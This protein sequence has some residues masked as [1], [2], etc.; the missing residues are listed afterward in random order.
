MAVTPDRPR[1][2]A[3]AAPAH[4]GV[5]R[6]TVRLPGDAS[7][8]PRQRGTVPSQRPTGAPLAV[9]AVVTTTWAALLAAVPVAAVVALAQLVDAPTVSLTG[10]V[11]Y[12]LAGWLLA[13]G[14]P[15]R[16][17]LG[18]VGLAPLAVTA[19]AA[20]RVARAG[21]HT[22]RAI[23]ARRSGSPRLAGYAAAAVAAVYGLLGAGAAAACRSADLEVSTLRAGLT[24]GF[25]GFVAAG[26]GALRASGAIDRAAARMP[27]VLRD[28][29][30]AGALAGVLLLAAGG[31]LAGVATAVNGKGA[32]ETLASY[33][34]GVAGQA[35]L[36]LVCLAYAPNVA[37]WA[38][39]YLIGPGFAVGVD[40]TVR[41]SDV[42]VG[43][44][45]A[46]P[47]F[48]GLPGSAVGGPWMML[49]GA[50]LAA[51]M[52]AGWVLVRRRLHERPRPHR[53]PPATWS[54]LLG[55]AA[56][57]GPVA[58]LALGAAAYA[59]AGPLGAGRLSVVGPFGWQVALVAA[60]VVALGA[61]LGAASSRAAT[62]RA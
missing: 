26:A 29:V 41:T 55:S 11:R 6:G 51:G 15:L 25:F 50:P 18:P 39:S 1:E 59:S 17:G 58:G 27:Y 10:V 60:G 24:L 19:L 30:R 33:G 48:A 28:A 12:G 35:G 62:A 37:V 56:L 23:G 21:V 2:A 47:V 32:S 8:L 22:T 9:A 52:V 36:T 3:P 38:A 7:R 42:S 40:T 20:W 13:H 31:V 57:A 14:V 46:V 45:P 4:R 44:L 54:R 43:A 5:Q 49:L 53:E 16:T 34:T 61:V